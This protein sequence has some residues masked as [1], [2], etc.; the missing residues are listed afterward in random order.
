LDE[1]LSDEN[2]VEKRGD[3]DEIRKGRCEWSLQKYRKS[4]EGIVQRNKRKKEEQREG[5]CMLFSG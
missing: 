2:H 4:E 1:V 3:L 5:E